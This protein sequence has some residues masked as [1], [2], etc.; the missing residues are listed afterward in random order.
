[1]KEKP[2]NFVKC[3]E[4]GLEQA[5]RA[6]LEGC[7]G[8][9]PTDTVYGLCA[10]PGCPQAVERLYRLKGRP[11]GKPVAILAGGEEGASR[12]IGYEAARFGARYWPGALT[13][14]AEGEGVRV[15]AHEWTRRLIERCGGA[16]R[17]TSANLSGGM[18][19][20]DCAEA[21]AELGPGCDFTVD[22][23][24]SPGGESS[25][26]VKFGEGPGGIEILRDGPVKFL[27]LASGSPRRAKILR[28][29][30]VYFTVAK[31]DAEEV[32]Y[33]GDPE[34]T[35][36]ENALL[37]G[38]S[39]PGVLSADTVVAFG[40]RIYGKP[41]DLAEA[42]RFLGELSG[43]VHSVY[44]AVAYG[45]EVKIVRSDVKMK[46]LSAEV[47]EDYIHKVHPLD[48]AG[49]YDIDEFGDMIVESYTNG[50]ENIMGLPMEPLV[51]WG[52]V[53]EEGGRDEA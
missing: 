2:Q 36:R 25:T 14:V 29:H 39:M 16:L 51:E 41:R 49:A 27:V 5:A 12:F 31:S 24:I 32:C 4:Q 18:P 45:G 34:R 23:G 26:V 40:G 43:N 15:P 52:I 53:K 20:I 44:T 35:V 37:K 19:A 9:I 22:G 30:G 7:I 33:E 21:F 10:H 3:D 11:E 17:V 47:I 1:M 6:L 13:V 42:A 38:S 8:V 50:Y 48:R 46:C 28:D